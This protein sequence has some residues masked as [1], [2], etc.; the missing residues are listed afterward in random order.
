MNTMCEI[1]QNTQCL[2]ARPSFAELCSIFDSY[3]CLGADDSLKMD[4]YFELAIA[5]NFFA[6]NHFL[7]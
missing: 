6:D 3:N 5:D 7:Y 1:G 2:V 4:I